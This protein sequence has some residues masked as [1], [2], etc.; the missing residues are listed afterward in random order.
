MK[1]TKFMLS[2]SRI[3]LS[4]IIVCLTFCSLTVSAQQ[5]PQQNSNS[6]VA[7][8]TRY[9]IKPAYQGRFREA[10]S[11]YV[12]QAIGKEH[13]IMAEAYTEQEKPSVFWVI[14]RWDNRQTFNEAA[15]G[16]QPTSLTALMEQALLYPAAIT[17][18][19]DLEPLSRQQW[20]KAANKEDTPLVIMLFVDA[21]PGTEQHFKEVYHTAMPQFRGESGVINY[22]LS[23]LEEDSTRFV[24][25]EKFRSEAAFQYHLHFPPIQPVIDFLNT[26][27][28]KQP[29]QIGLHRL[30][31]FPSKMQ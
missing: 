20:R 16:K 3:G 8:L 1:P 15:K 2:F 5:S 4:W 7:V 29:F 22:Q 27:I 11:A 25:Y 26:S 21:K 28:V 12:T 18:V 24:T 10:L 9:E 6:A 13:N 23:Q 30:V 31:P 17:Y 14:E 19:K